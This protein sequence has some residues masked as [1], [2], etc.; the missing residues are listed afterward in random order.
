MAEYRGEHVC[1]CICQCPTMQRQ[2]R[3]WVKSD[4]YDCLWLSLR[5]SARSLAGASLLEKSRTGGGWRCGAGSARHGGA[6]SVVMRGR[7]GCRRRRAA[8]GR[9][10]SI[11]TETSLRA[12]ACRGARRLRTAAKTN[13][14]QPALLGR[15]PCC[16]YH[17][18][19]SW[20]R[21][22]GSVSLYIG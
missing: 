5:N 20:S 2:H 22:R 16:V 13:R 7:T 6:A 10:R 4:I 18:T 3:T 1:L 11:F 8:A 14:V 17:P 21:R 15:T 12:A 9:P 19:T